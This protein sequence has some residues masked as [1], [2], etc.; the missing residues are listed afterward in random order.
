MSI[1]LKTSDGAASRQRIVRH[2][3]HLVREVEPM[4]I[5]LEASAALPACSAWVCHRTHLV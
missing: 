1:V 3:T 4:A 2:K 5:A